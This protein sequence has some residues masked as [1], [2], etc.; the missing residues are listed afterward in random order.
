VSR[1]VL[2]GATGFVGC[3]VLNALLEAGDEVCAVARRR[4]PDRVGVKWCEADLLAGCELVEACQPEILLHLAWY[5]EHGKFWSS[6]ENVPWVE[7]SLA[8]L[9][10]F[11]D[12]GG[13]RAVV[14]GTCAEYQWGGEQDMN[15]HDSPLVPL[16]LYG[17][18][19]DALRRVASAYASESALEL[20]WGRLF[21]L[22]GPREQPARLVPGVIRALLAG[23]RVATTA[24]TQIRDFMHVQDVAAA[25]VALVHS[26]V[27]GPVNIASG[28]PTS[29]AE[30][31]DLIGALTGAPHLIDRG[32]RPT[33]AFEPTRI[34]ADVG[35]ME[36]EVSF[37]P[38]ISLSDG[39]VST[40]EWWRGRLHAAPATRS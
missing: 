27:T 39:L 34:V 6:V 15:E 14:A 25:L 29:V 8:L 4:G 1:V 10:A 35:R 28:R 40:V 18:C 17:V 33:P 20:A 38:S 13:R 21:F 30:V 7:A 24:G 9:R 22:Y 11:A 37:R 36:H 3:S 32:A 12:A 31:L 2:T 5:G 23:E 19:K 26:D 16:T